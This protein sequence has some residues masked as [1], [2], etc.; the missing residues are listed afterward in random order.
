MTSVL[1]EQQRLPAK[2]L[3]V[4]GLLGTAFLVGQGLLRVAVNFGDRAP[5]V[6][7]A[8]PLLCAVVIAILVDPRVGPF[9]VIATFPIGAS[10]VLFVQ[11]VQLATLV[12]VGLVVIRRLGT[13]ATPL[14]MA[15]A[16]GWVVALLAWMLVALPSAPDQTRATREVTLFAVGLL[17]ASVIVASCRTAADTRR[18]LLF[19]A[20]LVGA[21]AA[22]TPVQSSGVQSAF[23]GAVISGRATGV[24][25]EPNQLGTFCAAGSLVAIGLALG[26]ETR[27]RRLLGAAL[28]LCCVTG[29]LLS[30]SRG[31]W[32][33]F[34][35]G[36]LILLVKLPE[37]RRWLLALAVPM[38]VVG[39][40]VGAFAPSSPRWRWLVSVCSPSPARGTPTTIVQICGGKR[41]AR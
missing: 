18:L 19:L 8:L 10:E 3:V 23:S 38:L 22:T 41:Y 16:M 40:A 14:P 28:S 6:V 2:V 31:A 13:G 29:L 11:L 32:I 5:V 7:L 26:A 25:V 21:I 24:F 33:G 12:V 27:R 39:T 30:L 17:L 9:A 4:S 15:P 20:I 35:L 36:M 37:A 34:T 1:T